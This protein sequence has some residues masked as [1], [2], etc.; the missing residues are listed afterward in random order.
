[1]SEQAKPLTDEEIK[2]LREAWGHKGDYFAAQVN[3]FIATIDALKAD[4]KEAMDIIVED[5]GWKPGSMPASDE[6]GPDQQAG[7]N[8]T[9]CRARRLLRKHGRVK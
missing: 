6:P 3:A 1:M 7:C 4:F 2:Q 8:C 9:D 5:N